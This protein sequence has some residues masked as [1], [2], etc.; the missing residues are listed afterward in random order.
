MTIGER[1]NLVEDLRDYLLK[2]ETAL[3]EYHQ[4]MQAEADYAHEELS[5]LEQDMEATAEQLQLKVGDL[6]S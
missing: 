6:G 2:I 5:R 3:D 4:V 1:A